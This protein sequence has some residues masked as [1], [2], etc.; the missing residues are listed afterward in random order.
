MSRHGLHALPERDITQVPH[1]PTPGP[2]T[3][4]DINKLKKL[5]EAQEP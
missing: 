5:I 4:L 1:P 3:K 2:G